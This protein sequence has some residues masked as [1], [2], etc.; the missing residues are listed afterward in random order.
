[1]NSQTFR[2]RVHELLDQLGGEVV[3]F[4]P[5]LDLYSVAAGRIEHTETAQA[6]AVVSL[7]DTLEE[8]HMAVQAGR[9]GLTLARE[10]EHWLLSPA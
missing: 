5:T 7:P 1:M 10:G 4:E 6:V 9:M 8:A 2:T 3:N